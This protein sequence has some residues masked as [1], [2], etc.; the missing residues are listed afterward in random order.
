MARGAADA[1]RKTVP[2]FGVFLI[3]EIFIECWDGLG[4]DYMAR[5]VRIDG[6]LR[7]SRSQ[8]ANCSG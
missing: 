2:T 7:A 6:S 1:D 4:S 5:A 8:G 3:F